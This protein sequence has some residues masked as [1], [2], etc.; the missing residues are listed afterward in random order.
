MQVLGIQGRIEAW[1]ITE[2]PGFLFRVY[3][4]QPQVGSRIA[5]QTRRH[6][7]R[8]VSDRGSGREIGM[9]VSGQGIS[10]IPTPRKPF[11]EKSNVQAV[12]SQHVSFSGV[13]PCS[14][15]E[16]PKPQLACR[17]SLCAP[18]KGMSGLRGII[19]APSAK[20]YLTDLRFQT[21]STPSGI[22]FR[23]SSSIPFIPDR[24][25]DASTVSRRGFL[26]QAWTHKPPD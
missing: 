3:T 1:K 22:D 14:T 21:S 19:I 2:F 24:D 13:S 10:L 8:M 11:D 6:H 15:T 25:S 20:E 9:M 17:S 7:R 16:C 18:L 5:T 4:V 12:A 26:L 23:N